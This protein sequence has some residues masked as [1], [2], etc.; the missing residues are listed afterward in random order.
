MTASFSCLRRA[1]SACDIHETPLRDGWSHAAGKYGRCHAI[2]KDNCQYICK[3]SLNVL[4][5]GPPHKGR[6]KRHSL[7]ATGTPSRERSNRSPRQSRSGPTGWVRRLA[8]LLS[9]LCLRDERAHLDGGVAQQAVQVLGPGIAGY[10]G[11]LLG[12]ELVGHVVGSLRRVV[13]GAVC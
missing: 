7:S 8:C 6:A 12:V 3:D 2:C 1:T 5:E 4:T 10:L 13:G 9:V 11:L